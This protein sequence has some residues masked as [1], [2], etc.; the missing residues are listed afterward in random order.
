[1]KKISFL[2]LIIHILIIAACNAPQAPE[3]K[4]VENVKIAGFG[5]NSVTL[6]GDALFNNPNSFGL[7]ITGADLDIFVDGD[8]VGHIDQVAKAT[9]NAKSDF[10]VPLKTL[11]SLSESSK[12]LIGKALTVLGNK[13][14]VKT[15]IKGTITVD[16]LGIPIPIPVEHEEDR[17]LY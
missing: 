17:Q 4:N 10:A 15:K 13:G 1:M 8:K 12:G 2:F 9:V 7:T 11:L 6:T 5:G 14:K 3:F 16:A